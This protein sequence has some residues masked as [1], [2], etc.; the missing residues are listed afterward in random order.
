[1]LSQFSVKNY[2]SIKDEMTFDM[3]AVAISEHTDRVIHANNNESILPV[4]AIYGPNGGGKSNVLQALHSLELKVLRPLYATEVDVQSRLRVRNYEIVPF[5]FNEDSKNS[6]TEF[7]VFF[8]TEKAE[9]RYI[10][11]VLAEKILYE[12]LSM[13]KVETNRTTEI[14]ERENGKISMG[15]GFG[16][17]KVSQDISDTLP[18]LSYLGITYRKN[19]VVDDCISWF[20]NGIRFLN[21]GSPM[22]ELRFAIANSADIKELILNMIR[23]MDLDIE[24]FKVE[25]RENGDI[26]VYTRHN[27][28][29][30]VYEI[31][32]EE[33]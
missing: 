30:N 16:R 12:S 25:K 10:L 19:E 26:H 18:L 13:R 29:G 27:V 2:K 23:E 28:S 4:A 11:H 33:E 31:N 22:Q 17:L 20:E 15:D 8:M 5:A 24:D 7:E 21:Y 1:M 32:L 3:Q 14:F 6:P 9:Y